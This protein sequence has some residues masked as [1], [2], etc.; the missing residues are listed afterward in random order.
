MRSPIR[1]GSAGAVR[2]RG[3][4]L[5]PS[6]RV[7]LLPVRLQVRPRTVLYVLLGWAGGLVAIS[8]GNYLLQTLRPEGFHL[9]ARLFTINREA[10]FPT[11]FQVMNLGLAAALSLAV[12]QS[13]A[14]PWRRYWYGLAVVMLYIS[15]DELSQL[16]ETLAVPVRSVLDTS[17]FFYFAWIIPGLFFVAGFALVYLRFLVNQ[18]RWLGVWLA[19]SGGVFVLGAIGMEG[20]TGIYADNR[21]VVDIEA[22][23]PRR[24]MLFMVFTHIEELLE[25]VGIALFNYTLLRVATAPSAEVARAA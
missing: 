7:A 10:N 8:F 4:P 24:A 19:L 17:G 3:V 14:T 20:V 12:A 5:I 6:S 21:A 25:M 11:W 23:L 16:H 2:P 13:T 9:P 22:A 1:R 15:A 18:P